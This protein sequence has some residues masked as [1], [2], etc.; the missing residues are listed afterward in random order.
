M[1]YTAEHLAEVVAK[2]GLWLKGDPAGA[3]AILSLA[4]LSG[5]NLSRADLSQA[6][7]T[8][9]NLARANLSR[10][11]LSLA[12]LS[13]A[14]L[15]GANLSGAN[16]AWADLAGAN[17]S[18]ADLSGANLTGA[19]L[20]GAD[21]PDTA[22]V[23]PDVTFGEF[24]SVVVPWLLIQ[25]G[26]PLA[27]AVAVWDCHTWENCPLHAAFGVESVEQMPVPL[28]PWATMFLSFFDANLLPKPEVVA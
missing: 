17:L 23:A 20:A 28:R 19:N 1:T 25:G 10:A 3:R 4:D 9:A 14:S 12:N 24:R 21:L 6:N 22:V 11:K 27:D 15:S 16:L 13:G 18:R 26:K 8:E 2:H 7:L 5:A